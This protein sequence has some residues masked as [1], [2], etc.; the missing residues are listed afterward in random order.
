MS[1]SRRV[2]EELIV[3]MSPSRH[4]RLA[5]LAAIV[6]MTGHWEQDQ[7]IMD[8]EHEYVREK[9]QKLIK[10]LAID[11]NSDEGRAGLK[12]KRTDTVEVG[13][14][15]VE[16][17]CCKQ[18]FLR[19]AFLS[20]GSITNPEK[21][22]HMELAC[23]DEDIARLIMTLF[24]AFSLEPKLI[25]RKK[26]YVVYFKDGSQITDALNLLGAH[27]A[28]M[29]MENVRILKDVRNRINRNVNCET[30]NSNK[31][32]KAGVKQQEDIQLI[33]EKR[34]LNYLSDNLREIAKLRLEEPELP[35]KELG[36]LLQPP[37]GKSGV[38]HRLKKI[39]EIAEELR[40][41]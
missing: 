11:V 24:G 35:L 6:A 16:R 12:L 18:A 29:E 3:N 21:G 33:I 13:R 14:Q 19:G 41:N 26:Y 1:F 28:L 23:D 38:N 17:A 20:V 25:T 22:Y 40:R 15:I 8:L 10:L 34:G 5:E 30:A 39:S 9:Q 2:K 36:E 32:V 37:L 31:A 7:W 4:C 27:K